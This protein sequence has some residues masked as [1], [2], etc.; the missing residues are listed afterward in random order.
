M[1]LNSKE[2]NELYNVVEIFDLGGYISLKD[3]I[4]FAND[5]ER[6][7]VAIEAIS[8]VRNLWNYRIITRNIEE[9]IY[10]NKVTN[11]FEWLF[12]IG[13]TRSKKKTLNFDDEAGTIYLIAY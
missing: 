5:K 12:S 1:A 2:G 6:E 7:T 9:C 4:K 3:Y 11:N 8:F 10:I 13:C